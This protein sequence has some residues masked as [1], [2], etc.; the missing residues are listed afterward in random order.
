MN[1]TRTNPILSLLRTIWLSWIV[2]GVCALPC[3]FFLKVKGATESLSDATCEDEKKFWQMYR[4]TY[5]ILMYWSI[6]IIL[7]FLQAVFIDGDQKLTFW[8]A[9]TYNWFGLL[10]AAFMDKTMITEHRYSALIITNWQ[11]CFGLAAIGAVRYR[12]LGRCAQHFVWVPPDAELERRN[13][14]YDTYERPFQEVTKQLIDL[15]Y[16]NPSFKSVTPDFDS[17]PDAEKARMMQEW[18]DKLD[19]IKAQLSAMPRASSFH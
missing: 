12:M 5:G 11:Y 18:R 8:L 14:L 9:S 7:W 10:H 15:E 17:L 19:A 13:Q 3:H 2:I 4:W 1:E 6:T 16:A